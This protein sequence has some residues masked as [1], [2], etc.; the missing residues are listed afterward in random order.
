MSIGSATRKFFIRLRSVRGMSRLFSDYCSLTTVSVGQSW[1]SFS[2]TLL[3]GISALWYLKDRH[4]GS[5]RAVRGLAR[6][7]RY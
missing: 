7:S 2:W 5:A 6:A 3:G 4:H 1:A